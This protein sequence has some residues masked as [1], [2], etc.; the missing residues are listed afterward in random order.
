MISLVLASSSPRRLA[1]LAQIG[2]VPSRV[3]SPDIDESP[4]KGELPRVYALRLAVAKARAEQERIIKDQVEPIRRA[5]KRIKPRD[6]VDL[7]LGQAEK[8]AAN[9][10]AFPKAADNHTTPALEAAGEAHLVARGGHARRADQC[11]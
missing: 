10:L 1:L 4:L 11:G 9:V 7:I 8:D 2:V 5:A 3:V 6:M